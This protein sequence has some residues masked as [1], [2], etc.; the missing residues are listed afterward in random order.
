MLAAARLLEEAGVEP[1]MARATAAWLLGL[2]E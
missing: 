2:V 1:L